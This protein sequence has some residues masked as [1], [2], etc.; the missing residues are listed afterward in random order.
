MI[1]GSTDL[2]NGIFIAA[3]V[4]I[5]YQTWRGWRRGVLRQAAGLGALICA[6]LAGFTAAKVCLPILSG[7]LPLPDLLIAFSLGGLVGLVVYFCVSVLAALTFKRTEHQ[8]VGP[9]RW[10]FGAGG[11]ALGLVYGAFL[12]WGIFAIIRTFGTVAEAQTSPQA[13]QP[14]T[15]RQA[16]TS[17][18]AK[19]K[20]SLDM[21]SAGAAVKAT[22]PMP[23]EVYRIL[24]K[25]VRLL[26]SEKA[27][28]AFMEYPGAQDLITHPKVAALFSD[29]AVNHMAREKDFLGLMQNPAMITAIND[30]DL[31]AKLKQFEFEAALDYALEQ[32][33]NTDP[34]PQSE[35]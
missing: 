23:E 29:P 31:S 10:L 19:L 17:Q 34:L 2:Q 5:L 32:S 26:T 14:A 11:A 7:R 30:P 12:V 27:M 28:A 24:G 9:I 16:L 18:L 1:E 25:S 20:N 13:T 22:D 33:S 15:G 35:P 6:Y 8:S 3:G 21:G 4:F